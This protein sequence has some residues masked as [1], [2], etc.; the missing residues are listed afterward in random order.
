M[1]KITVEKEWKMVNGK[2]KDVL[3]MG[4]MR[5][6]SWHYAELPAGVETGEQIRALIDS[7]CN[8][9]E[10]ELHFSRF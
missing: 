10:Y 5:N 8:G 7:R 4:A 6:G 1:I 3:V 2:G 9:K